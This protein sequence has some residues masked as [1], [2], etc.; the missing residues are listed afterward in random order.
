MLIDYETYCQRADGLRQQIADACRVARR[1]P[2][3]VRLLPVTKNHPAEAA[4]Y[5]ARYGLT[6][7]GEN[8]V[9]EAVEKRP[10]VAAAL[11]WEHS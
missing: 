11:Q 5:A 4:A 10:L 6:A 8:R 1:D 7:V 9:Q 2:Q 3:E